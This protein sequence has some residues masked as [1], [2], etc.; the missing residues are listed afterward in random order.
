MTTT[1]SRPDAA[2]TA[3]LDR[4]LTD[5]LDFDPVAQHGFTNHLAMG[6]TAAARL[7]A[8]SD[9]LER[10]YETEATGGFIIRRPSRPPWLDPEA[11]AVTASGL[12]AA[13]AEALPRLLGRP[14]AALFH[15][16]IRLDLA[17]DAGHPGQVANALHDLS[18][19][20]TPL[21]SGDGASDVADGDAALA[22]TARQVAERHWATGGFVTLHHV[23]GTRAARALAPHLDERDRGR[24]AAAHQRAVEDV[25]AARAEPAGDP[26]PIARLEDQPDWD[27]IGRAAVAS[28]DDHTV[29]LAYASRLE[30]LTTGDPIYRAMAARRAGLG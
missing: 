1:S 22:R 21:A 27:E 20:A 28:G 19:H 18:R 30:E 16:I 25:I 3:T 26:D 5:E 4:L 29:K 17:L 12:D 2:A 15:R 8:T 14:G 23:T 11:Q 9:E 7:G 24:L 6:L 10:W 13:V